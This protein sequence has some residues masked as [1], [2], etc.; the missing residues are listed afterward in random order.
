M[1]AFEGDWDQDLA[2]EVS[3]EEGWEDGRE[4]GR[5]EYRGD[6]LALIEQGYTMEDL[7]RELSAQA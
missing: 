1:N 5:E 6:L 7:K 3:R 4:A 2:L